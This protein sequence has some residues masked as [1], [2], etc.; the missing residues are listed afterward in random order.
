MRPEPAK[1]F[2][3]PDLAWT[4]QQLASH[5]RDAFY[6]GE[7]AAKILDAMK[8]HNGVMAAQDLA[9]YSSEWVEPISTTYRD[10]TVFEM[11]P[12]GQGLAALEML[13]IMENFRLGKKSGD[14]ARPKLCTP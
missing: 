4:L 14:S 5:G 7:I 10:W 3:N 6:K 11:P 8:R 9:E 1:S 13:N 12:N 2:R